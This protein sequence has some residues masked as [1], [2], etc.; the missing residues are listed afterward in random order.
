MKK[1]GVLILIICLL[2]AAWT[3]WYFYYYMHKNIE[4][5][6]DSYIEEPIEVEEIEEIEEDVPLTKEEIVRQKIEKIKKRHAL[7]WLIIKW[8]SY[9]RNDQ[10]ALALKKYLEFYRE[11]SEDSLILEKIGDT[12]FEMKKFGSSLNYYSRISEPKDEVIDKIILSQFYTTDLSKPEEVNTLVDSLWNLWLSEEEYFYYTTS[13]KC[14]EDFHAC[15]LKFQNYF[16]PEDT[17]QESAEGTEV[18]E[19]G[20]NM[21]YKLSNIQQAIENYRNFQIDEVYLKNAY[22][23]GAWYSDGLYPLAIYMGNDLLSEKPWYKPILQINAQSYFELGEY[24]TA[25]DTLGQYYQ[26]DDD[27]PSVAYMLW[28]I[29]T[30]LR[31]YV[32]WN[33]YL[34]KSI[35]LGFEDSIEARRQLIYNFYTL[36]NTEAMLIEF[37]KLINEEED[38]SIEDLRLAIYHHI[39]NEKY[40]EA[41]SW[42]IKWQEKFWDSVDFYAYEWWILREQWAYE[43]ASLALEKWKEIEEANPFLLINIAYNELYQENIW[44]ALVTF[45]ILASD[46]PES[47]F[48]IQ[49]Q[50]EIE[51]LQDTDL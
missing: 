34:Q 51:S 30:K 31:E 48:G 25:R 29:N 18:A 6:K 2:W 26:E 8:D 37:Q 9:F 1:I 41:L 50:K 11:N 49:A 21:F 12:Y 35:K 22:I 45:K 43:R 42:A 24:E 7:K 32:L 46:F 33:I 15:K 13:L 4:E 38:Y 10:L 44:T 3:F 17:N 23:I 20:G 47:E 28:I 40:E 16:W 14:R 5:S 39:L 36:E 27:D 19:G